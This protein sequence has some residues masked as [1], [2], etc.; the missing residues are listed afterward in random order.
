MTMTTKVWVLLW[1]VGGIISCITAPSARADDNIVVRAGAPVIVDRTTQPITNEKANSGSVVKVVQGTGTGTTNVLLYVPPMGAT[2]IEDQV[3]YS[4][5]GQT[6]SKKIDVKPAAPTLTD[7]RFYDKSFNGLF[8]LFILAVIVENGLAL[9]FRWRP[10]LDYFDARAVNPLVTFA[11]SLLLV[12]RFKLDIATTLINTYTG[13]T[14]P[15][16]APGMWLTAAIIAGGSVGV[17]RVFQALGF[18]S[19]LSQ[20]QPTP[21]PPR[22]DAWIAVTLVRDK[23][24]GP[25]TVLIGP[26]ASPTVA[27]VITGATSGRSWLRYFVRA[28]G[29]F[30]TTGGHTVTPGQSCVVMLRGTD[31][32]GNSVESKP[33]GPH[34]LAAGAI[35][36]IELT[37]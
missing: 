26:Q 30:P 35:V 4:V 23:A 24:V 13:A 28:K 16:N 34:E 9:I 37:T 14:N 31:K 8:A 18:R 32:D 25:V 15:V 29:R 10:F 36:D 3:Q 2:D 22:T 21:K 11:F 6:L 5:E 19:V 20:A 33:W 1:V 12:W 7:P 17:N 27:G